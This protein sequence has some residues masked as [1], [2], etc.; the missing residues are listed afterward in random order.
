M[1]KGLQF[2]FKKEIKHRQILKGQRNEQEQI[3][4]IIYHGREVTVTSSLNIRPHACCRKRWGR[5]PP[6]T[7]VEFINSDGGDKVNSGIGLSHRPARL[8]GLTCRYDNPMPELTLS[9]SQGSMNS[10]TV[11]CLIRMY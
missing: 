6:P 11:I 5:N 2:Q 3:H 9:L 8:H 1:L 7:V 4:E 10:A